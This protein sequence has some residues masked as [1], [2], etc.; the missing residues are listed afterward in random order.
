MT[1]DEYME[2]RK[3]HTEMLHQ[4]S[5][6]WITLS[7]IQEGKYSQYHYKY[8]DLLKAVGD[9][10]CYISMNTFFKP[11]RRIET[12]KEL[13]H[14]YIDLAYEI[15]KS[16][17]DEEKIKRIETEIKGIT[18]N[19]MKYIFTEKEKE[20]GIENIILTILGS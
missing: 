14:L 18:Y 19:N 16:Q 15:K 10:N 5:K 20:N 8:K 3:K 2:T 6:G 11:Q 17:G 13:K 4:E 9:S 7:S 12:V 1:I